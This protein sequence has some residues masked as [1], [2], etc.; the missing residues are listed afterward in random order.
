[1]LGNIQRNQHSVNRL[2]NQMATQRLISNPSENPLIATRA[3]RFENTRNQI[4]QH[5]RN[6]SQA[7]AWTEIT[8][9]A[10]SDLVDVMHRIEELLNRADGI[11]TVSDKQIFATEINAMIEEKMSIMNKSFAGRY[12][13]SG[14]R[15]DQPPFF[16][17]DQPDLQFHN[18]TKTFSRNDMETSYMLD[19]SPFFADGSDPTT[20]QIHR[21][22]LPFGGE[23]GSVMINGTAIPSIGGI[24]DT[25]GRLPN[26]EIDLSGLT[27]GEIYHDPETGTLLVVAQDST[28]TPPVTLPNPFNAFFDTPNGTAFAGA[29]VPA[30]HRDGVTNLGELTVHFDQNGFSRGDMNP[31]V[32]FTVTDMTGTAATNPNHGLQFN[33]DNQDIEFEF[34]INT[35]INMNLLAKNL[36]TPNMFADLRSFANDINAMRITDEGTLRVELYTPGMTE[37][38]LNEAIRTFRIRE[39]AMFDSIQGDM[40]NNM[41]G[42]ITRYQDD[43]SSQQTELGTRMVRLEMIEDRLRSDNLT[44]E[45]LQ[46]NNIGTDMAEAA[47][48][49][50]TAEV[51]LTASLQVGMHN[52]MNLTLLNFL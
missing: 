22:R 17:R 20:V 1:M 43:I 2:M 13:F 39:A 8:E 11:E 51:A 7:Q 49:F 41:I 19:R 50:M 40:F 18:M 9:Q 30:G 10:V 32:F 37:A 23:A 15:T 24:G 45:E 48:R 14:L 21:L 44:F 33:M 31:L 26:G 3:L 5:Q 29:S 6:V 46:T 16:T 47:S 42:R 35:R 38:E 52:L 25:P 12:I 28:V 34:G 27:P 4:E 36:V